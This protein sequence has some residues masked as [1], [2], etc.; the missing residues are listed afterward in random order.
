MGR[1]ARKSA[2]AY[3][4]SEGPDQPAHPHSLTRNITKCMI[5]KDTW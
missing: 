3:A 4:E 2:R 1:A 5:G